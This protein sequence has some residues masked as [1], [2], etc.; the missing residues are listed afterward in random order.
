MA[1]DEHDRLARVALTYLTAPGDPDVHTQVTRDG[2]VAT[3]RHLAQA[4][5]GWQQTAHVRRARAALRTRRGRLIVPG[6]PDWPTALDDLTT[7]SPAPDSGIAG[8]APPLALWVTG[9]VDPTTVLQRAVT[10]TGSRAATA[11]GLH[12]ATDIATGC[13]R[14]GWTIVAAGNFGIDAAAH[15]AALTTEAPTV[16]VLPGSLDRPH[17]AGHHHLFDYIRSTGLLITE[18]PPGTDVIRR[19][20]LARQ[21]L[22]AALTTGT[23]LVEATTHTTYP[24]ITMTAATALNRI[25]MAVPGPVTSAQS[26]GCHRALRDRRVHLVTNADDV[27][28]HLH[29]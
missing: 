7:V 27:L 28:T 8:Y 17:P 21:R 20:F 18:A 10:I 14:A 16:A 1:S 13:T 25:A 12:V 29:H 19:R 15:R 9:A 3:Y 22:L 23:V 24:V 26:A 2:A 6:E 11:Y 5:T 4:G